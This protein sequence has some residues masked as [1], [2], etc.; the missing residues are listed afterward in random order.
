MAG[1]ANG[2]RPPFSVTEELL[3]Y[4]VD[5]LLGVRG[6]GGGECTRGPYT[7]IKALMLAVLDNGIACYMSSNARL[8]S[9]AEDWVRSSQ[10]RSPFCF[11][12]VCETLG[13]E[14]NAVRTELRRWREPGTLPDRAFSRRRPN[15]TRAR[16]VATR[17]P[18]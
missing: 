9:E 12:V 11:Q 5:D 8:R 2:L 18:Q 13:L 4:S 16:R 10:R 17:D 3:E 15:V 6:I 1:R 7:G 14:P